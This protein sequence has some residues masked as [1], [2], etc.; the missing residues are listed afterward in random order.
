[1]LK[2]KRKIFINKKKRFHLVYLIKRK[3]IKINDT[4]QHF[5][6]SEVY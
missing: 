3:G 4:K 5:L 2:T 6:S 1:M